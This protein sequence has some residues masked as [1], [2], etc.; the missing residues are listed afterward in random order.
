M[1]GGYIQLNVRGAEDKYFLNNP[2]ISYFKNVFHR[3]YNFSKN[4]F[5]LIPDEL[6]LK[7]NNEFSLK[8]YRIK[9][10]KK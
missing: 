2:S 7:K 8:K 3:Y 6:E 9:L 5:T 10:P 4:L 1:P